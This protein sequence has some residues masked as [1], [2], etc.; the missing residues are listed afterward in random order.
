MRSHYLTSSDPL[1][2]ARILID[3]RSGISETLLPPLV[4]NLI[5]SKWG[6][7]VAS[8]AETMKDVRSTLEK[9][10]GADLWE[11][12]HK[13]AVVEEATKRN[14][15]GARKKN[16]GSTDEAAIPVTQEGGVERGSSEI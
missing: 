12:V 7:G 3:F 2:A 11:K 1:A 6:P 14:L 13:V 9:A 15:Q 16:G 10:F 5:S 4:N 8:R